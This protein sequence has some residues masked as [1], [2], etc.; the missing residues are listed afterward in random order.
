MLASK[1]SSCE[2]VKVQSWSSMRCSNPFED[3]DDNEYTESDFDNF[4]EIV[5][6]EFA[7]TIKV[8]YK[9]VRDILYGHNNEFFEE[10]AMV[11]SD[12]ETIEARSDEFKSLTSKLYLPTTYGL[13]RQSTVQVFLDSF[14]ELSIEDKVEILDRLTKAR[15]DIAVGPNVTGNITDNVIRSIIRLSPSDQY[16]VVKKVFGSEVII[17]VELI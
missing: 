11:F 17:D 12:I 5:F 4:A 13:V 15:L 7:E 14:E 10:K 3:Y 9:D 6:R 1:L 8:R 2:W 16:E